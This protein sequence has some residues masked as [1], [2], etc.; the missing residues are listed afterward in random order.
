M[1]R[2]CENINKIR[3]E[4]L[5]QGGALSKSR[6]LYQHINIVLH[7][8]QKTILRDVEETAC[9]TKSFAALPR[10][11]AITVNCARELI[12]GKSGVNRKASKSSKID[13]RGY[14]TLLSKE[15]FN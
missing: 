2:S 10:F 7:C 3:K 4:I 11:H 14:L 8:N 12:N 13:K 9:A 5:Y 6:V 1:K 15:C